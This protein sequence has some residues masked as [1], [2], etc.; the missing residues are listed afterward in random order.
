MDNTNEHIV[1]NNIFIALIMSYNKCLTDVLISHVLF[2]L[3]IYLCP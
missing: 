3:C 1:F 2:A